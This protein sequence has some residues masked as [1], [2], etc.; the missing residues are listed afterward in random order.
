MPGSV[1]TATY[2]VKIGRPPGI[3]IESI[4]AG[5]YAYAS[6]SRVY[7]NGAQSGDFV[8]TARGAW[9][10]VTRDITAP[11]VSVSV[12]AR[13]TTGTIPVSW[14]ATDG[15]AE[16]PAL[17]YN[18]DQG[19]YL[20]AWADT[21]YDPG[22]L[23]G[24]ILVQRVSLT[25]TL[26]GANTAVLSRTLDEFH[27]A[28]AYNPVAGEYLVAALGGA[29]D[30]VLAQRVSDA[31]VAVGGVIT[32][33][34]PTPQSGAFGRPAVA[35]ESDGESVVVWTDQDRTGLQRLTASGA[36]IGG[37]IV[38]DDDVNAED[39][40]V[41]Y[42]ADDNSH[43]VAWIGVGSAY[44]RV[45]RPVDA[46]FSA[47]PVQGSAP[48]TVTFTNLSKPAASITSYL[49]NFG[50]GVTSTIT[51]PVHTYT[52]TGYF[53]VT[54]K[55]A[56]GAEEETITRTNFITVTGGG[57]A[58]SLITTTIVYIYDPLYRLT[59]AAYSGAY[60]YTFAY[61]YDAVGN[62]TVQTRTI[63]ST[64]V[65]TY[66]YDA[67]NRLSAVGGQAYTWDA[68][69]NLLDDGE[70]TY[71]YNQANRLTNVYA[72]GLTWSA[73]YNGDGAR[74][75]QVTNGVPT[76]YTLDLAAPLVQVLVQQD[77]SGLTRY[78]YGVTRVGE[79]QPAGWVYHLPDALGS[80]RQ[81]A[82][83]SAQ[84]A[85][86][87]GYMPY[88]EV[89]WS[90]GE[91]GSVYGFTG[92]AFDA[93]VGLVF[94]R[95]RYMSPG[96][97]MFLSKDKAAVN[98]MQPSDGGVYLY[99]NANPTNYAD[100]SGLCVFCDIGDSVKVYGGAPHTPVR[101]YEQPNEASR[102][103]TNLFDGDR[104]RILSRESGRGRDGWREVYIAG[105]VEDIFVTG[106]IK[107]IELLDN[108]DGPA[109]VFACLPTT[110]DI[111]PTYGFGP[112][113]FAYNQCANGGACGDYWDLRGLH[114]GLDFGVDAGN[115]LVWMGTG[116][117]TVVNRWPADAP[118]NIEIE[119]EGQG[120]EAVFGHTS[121]QYP[122]AAEGRTVRSGQT[123][124]ESGGDHL[125]LGVRNGRVFYNPIYYFTAALRAPIER[126]MEPYAR[127]Y[128]AYSMIWYDADAVPDGQYFWTEPCCDY[129][130]ILFNEGTLA[131]CE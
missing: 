39:A 24:D 130:G 47:S 25:G 26:V 74:L 117:G 70:K 107:N 6:G 49:W 77:G 33:T 22:G 40:S 30:S 31:G 62:R 75:R 23:L 46:D 41:A 11:V 83:S 97:G 86:A 95:A 88:G 56:A 123:I 119:F 128:D 63:T 52:Q 92:E 18:P 67:A 79:L 100:P 16:R 21:R 113:M 29:Y 65:T 27:A 69:G 38:V 98:M 124:G 121:V 131:E 81:L 109:G 93:S 20:V 125:H 90:A 126:T 120:V 4:A 103:I 84:V 58:P 68:N 91:G 17:A 32:V 101:V 34:T 118:D 76:T 9:F 106:W 99:A 78:L 64:L 7:Y 3:L 48:L 72:G 45:F 37:A 44:A 35:V 87:R 66:T 104:V 2:T 108:C 110:G 13:V 19:H 112:N 73:A 51:N 102:R 94:L 55:A 59:N 85:L 42:G 71:T 12:P 10:T 57:A 127:H 114:N 1:L 15:L 50:D 28:V 8:V 105:K 5:P 43:L 60:T 61:A 115:I 80:V 14:S 96:L 111:A 53:T 116:D 89:L 36:F 129:P 82:D 54:L 122:E